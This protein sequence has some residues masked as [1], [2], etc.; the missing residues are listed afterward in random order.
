V[1]KAAR[2]ERGARAAENV[3]HGGKEGLGRA[4]SVPRS[5]PS[6]CDSSAAVR[7]VCSCCVCVRV[8]A[9]D[10][11]C[12]ANHRAA[13]RRRAAGAATRTAAE[14]ARHARASGAVR[15]RD[16]TDEGNRCRDEEEQW[17]SKR[18]AGWPSR[19]V[20][21]VGHFGDDPSSADNTAA[22]QSK[23][24]R[25]NGGKEREREGKGKG[26]GRRKLRRWPFMRWSARRMLS[27]ARACARTGEQLRPIWPVASGCHGA[28]GD[29]RGSQVHA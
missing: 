15:N 13:R 14:R 29:E 7:F 12:V 24:T 28:S 18:A 23:A 1:S 5:V 6:V 20:L 25:R 21:S 26:G 22:K 17:A 4:S 10:G 3:V 8:G 2:S 19:A 16:M 9:T 11:P 27:Y